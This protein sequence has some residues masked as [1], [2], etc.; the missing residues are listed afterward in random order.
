[1]PSLRVK[2]LEEFVDQL[3]QQQV[4]SRNMV[5]ALEEFIG[6]DVISSKLNP[7]KLT[8]H[9]TATLRDDVMGIAQ[10]AIAKY[11]SID[12]SVTLT[13]Y[14]DTLNIIG[15]QYVARVIDILCKIR[16]RMKNGTRLLDV[17]SEGKIKY[18]Y[19][20]GSLE[21]ISYFPILNIFTNH[22]DYLMDVLNRL[23]QTEAAE[24]FNFIETTINTEGDLGVD[25][26]FSG[27]HRFIDTDNFFTAHV[28]LLE[29]VTFYHIVKI[30]D[31]ATLLIDKLEAF[32]D[33]IGSILSAN[34]ES[35]AS[36]DVNDD[37]YKVMKDILRH[38]GTDKAT[39]PYLMLA[40]KLG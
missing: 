8:I 36:F 16:E 11:K 6:E 7:A 2:K 32:Q 25:F 17:I 38:Y 26:N 23:N 34:L 28:G 29:P 14:M 3:Q 19:I 40:S 18:R 24:T 1:M 15:N 5:F 30:Q 12:A 10:D 31:N 33:W 20:N 4:V 37:N 13:E 27:I 9:P 22:K 35:N 21:D 39:Y